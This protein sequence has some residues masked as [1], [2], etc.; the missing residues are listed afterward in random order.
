MG[1]P[2][3]KASPAKWRQ[4]GRHNLVGPS[5]WGLIVSRKQRRIDRRY[6]ATFVGYI[7]ALVAII[8][9]FV[10]FVVPHRP[11]FYLSESVQGVLFVFGVIWFIAWLVV[12][13]VGV[14]SRGMQRVFLILYAAII[15]FVYLAVAISNQGN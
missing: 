15:A 11:Y 7:A 3:E 9:L 14:F 5:V 4:D 1:R 8:A 2:A 13:I 10:G 12:L 6:L